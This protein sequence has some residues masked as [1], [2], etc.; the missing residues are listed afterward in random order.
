M[1]IVENCL[2]SGKGAKLCALSMRDFEAQI[3]ITEL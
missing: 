3:F 2:S 1:A